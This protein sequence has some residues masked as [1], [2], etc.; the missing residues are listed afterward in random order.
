MFL[1][2]K[3]RNDYYIYSSHN[4][5]LDGN[6]INSNSNIEMYYCSI[7]NGCRLLELDCWD[8]R[9][10]VPDE[11]I[12]THWYFMVGEINFKEVLINIKR[13]AFKKSEFPV[14]LSVENHCS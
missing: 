9:N 10:G 1:I 4:T 5:Y 8:G 13:W 3:I 2:L 14:I 6:Q 7:K 11:P 12:I